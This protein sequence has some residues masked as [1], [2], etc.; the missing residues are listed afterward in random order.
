MKLDIGCSSKKLDGY[1][2]L[3]ILPQPG[4]DI[5]QDI[6]VTPWPLADGCCQ[7][8]HASHVLEH[9]KPWRL[10]AVMDECWRVMEV[11]GEMTIRTPF[12][13]AYAFDPTHCIL[14]QESSFLYFD[15]ATKY[16]AIYKPQP[17]QIVAMTR[18]DANLELKTILKKR[19]A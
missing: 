10:I 16:H 4:V 6:E 15:S 2:G 5:V 8:I 1:L 9:L 18:D 19:P 7:A 13:A 3:D 17:W 14:F 12:G 11:G